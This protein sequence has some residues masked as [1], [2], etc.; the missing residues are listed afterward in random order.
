MKGMK[1]VKI[2]Y[3]NYEKK[4]F[5]AN[6]TKAVYFLTPSIAQVLRPDNNGVLIHEGK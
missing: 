4:L 5:P 6:N 1:Q 3:C 2:I